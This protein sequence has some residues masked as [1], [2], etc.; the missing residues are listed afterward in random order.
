[1]KINC[2]PDA[3]AEANDEETPALRKWGNEQDLS[4]NE[5]SKRVQKNLLIR[6]KSRSKKVPV[7][8]HLVSSRNDSAPKE[9]K[10]RPVSSKVGLKA[11][12]N[13]SKH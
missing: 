1:M 7:G 3:I 11:R 10:L 8:S 12:S 5:K 6:S 4:Q 2:F 13:Y 9:F